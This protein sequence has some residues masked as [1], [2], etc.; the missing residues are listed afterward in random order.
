MHD[1]R[2]APGNPHTRPSPARPTP[3]SYGSSARQNTAHR[4]NALPPLPPFISLGVCPATSPDPACS[5]LSAERLS[6]HLNR[7][8]HDCTTRFDGMSPC[9]PGKRSV[10][11]L[12]ARKTP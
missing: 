12:A 2:V 9:T 3:W 4:E 11:C 7:H 6:Y 5:L 8:Q 10:Q 1:L